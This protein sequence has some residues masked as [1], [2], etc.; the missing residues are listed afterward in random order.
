MFANTVPGRLDRLDLTTGRR[1]AW[2]T[3]MPE[4]PAG[5]VDVQRPVVTPDLSAY[6]YSYARYLQDLFLVDG[7]R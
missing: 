2:K 6:A 4:D 5:V 3:L 7:L 1:T